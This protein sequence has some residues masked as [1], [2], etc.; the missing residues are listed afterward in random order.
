MFVCV[1]MYVYYHIADLN[2]F[3]NILIIFNNHMH[4]GTST[5]AHT[6]M[7]THIELELEANHPKMM[8]SMSRGCGHMF[9]YHR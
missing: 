2:I 6:C 8:L 1:C 7:H 5:H 4:A 9:L 3:N